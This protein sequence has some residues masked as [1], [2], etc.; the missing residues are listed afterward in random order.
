MPVPY[1]KDDKRSVTIFFAIGM[2]L[3]KKK[4]YLLADKTDSKNFTAFLKV[5]KAELIDESS[6]VLLVAD[7]HGKFY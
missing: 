6:N 4:A 3:K 1:I 5:V 2:G 7:N